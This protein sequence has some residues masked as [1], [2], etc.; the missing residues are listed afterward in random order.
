MLKKEITYKDLD[1]NDVTETFWFHMTEADLSRIALGK[2]GKE[3]GF[4]AWVRRIRDSNDGEVIVETFEK[5][6]LSTI[7]RRSDDNRSFIKNDEIRDH[8]KGSEAYSKLFMEL[9]VDA[10]KMS[11]FINGVVPSALRD[12]VANASEEELQRLSS[13]PSEVQ[14]V[15]APVQTLADTPK[16]NRPEWMKDPKKIPTME[17]L[18][19]ATPEQMMEAF[20]RR[21]QAEKPE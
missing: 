19:G 10:E 14:Q 12:R 18:K 4:D 6:L 17:E 13:S 11:A 16:D 2:E 21:E 9:V 15:S 8:F 5:I 7:G 20:R 3:G 1:D